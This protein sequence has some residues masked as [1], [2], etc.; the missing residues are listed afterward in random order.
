MSES[1]SKKSTKLPWPVPPFVN[2]LIATIGLMVLCL[3]LNLWQDEQRRG[4]FVPAQ[5][6]VT[7]SKFSDLGW[8]QHTGKQYEAD[9]AFAYQN[10]GSSSNKGHWHFYQFHPEVGQAN[11]VTK[12]W[13]KGRTFTIYINPNNPAEAT[14]VHQ[15]SM[16]IYGLIITGLGLLVIFGWIFL[17]TYRQAKA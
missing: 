15:T 1:S 2:L 14:L 8:S 17:S 9:V 10:A 12:N 6:V 11:E 16:L 7:D 3:G 4:S 5:A 13:P